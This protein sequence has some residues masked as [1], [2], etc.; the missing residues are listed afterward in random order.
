MSKGSGTCDASCAEYKGAGRLSYG[1]HATRRHVQAS[2]FLKSIQRPPIYERSRTPAG[3]G[4]Q[5]DPA[6][7]SGRGLMGDEQDKLEIVPE[8]TVEVR[9]T[10]KLFRLTP[11]PN[12]D[13]SRS[14]RQVGI[15]AA[16]TEDEARQIA[17]M[18]DAFGHKSRDPSFAV[19]DIMETPETHV[20]GD[21]IFRSEPVATEGRKRARRCP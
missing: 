18:H 8:R 4:D 1:R 11:L 15:V 2:I 10:C 3:R 14:S 7:A 21:V 19:A 20:F 16:D 12:N 5:T 6:L 13:L 9:E 17:S